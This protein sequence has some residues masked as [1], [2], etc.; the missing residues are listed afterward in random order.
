MNLKIIWSRNRI[1]FYL[2]LIQSP[3][4]NNLSKV[5]SVSTGKLMN[6]SNE[7]L[8]EGRETRTCRMPDL[9]DST[10]V[11]A[12]LNWTSEAKIYKDP[13]LYLKCK[14][15]LLW[16]TNFWRVLGGPYVNT[17]ISY[18]NY[19]VK[20]KKWQKFE[21]GIL[22]IFEHLFKAILHNTNLNTFPPE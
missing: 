16:N 6:F 14:H 9:G 22:I 13:Y 10:Y 7:I 20:E 12:N 5:S 1:W 17:L 8:K 3:F 21:Q 11:Y 19:K 15:F 18:Y 4:E 2:L